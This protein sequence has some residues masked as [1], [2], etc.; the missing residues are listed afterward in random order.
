MALWR[1]FAAFDGRCSLRTWVYRVAVNHCLKYR[2]H[3]RP[4]SLPFDEATFEM[5]IN[6]RADPALSAMKS[7]GSV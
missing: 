4:D 3:T 5:D 2:Q 7:C 6:W 1:S